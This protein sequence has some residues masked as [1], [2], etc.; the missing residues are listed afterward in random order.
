MDELRLV[1]LDCHLCRLAEGRTTVVF[2]EGDPHADL[3]VVGEGPG[4]DEDIQGRP[5]VGRSGQLLNR[6]LAEEAGLP[7][8]AVYI[9]NVVKCR[10][11]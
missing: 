8:S 6:L 10:P 9:A 11:P 3:M 1:A 7:R 4:R 5:F 2:G